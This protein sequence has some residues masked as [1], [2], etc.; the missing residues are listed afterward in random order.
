MVDIVGLIR[1]VRRHRCNTPVKWNIFQRF[2]E[3]RQTN[4]SIVV[5]PTTA[6]FYSV[7]VRGDNGCAGLAGH[8]V[9]VVAKMIPVINASSTGV[10][11]GGSAVTLSFGGTN[12][13]APCTTAP[14][15]Q[16]PAVAH[17][18][19]NCNGTFE[20]ISD[21]GFAGK[22]SVVNVTAGKYYYFC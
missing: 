17:T 13:V 2:M 4:P 12:S 5:N 11:C 6:T 10:V 22:Y 3:Y 18:F 16:F 19:T 7:S 9:N 14:F 1:S 21:Q 20:L 8:W 15:G